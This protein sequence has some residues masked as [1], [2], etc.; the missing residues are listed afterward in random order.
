MRKLTAYVITLV[1]LVALYTGV[2]LLILHLY[3]DLPL[4]AAIILA[5]GLV[6]ILTLVSIPL[7][8]PIQR[9]VE[10]I[11]NRNKRRTAKK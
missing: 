9:F 8:Y 10:C 11:F 2:M 6:I 5:V 1:P 4:Y 7:R 3:P